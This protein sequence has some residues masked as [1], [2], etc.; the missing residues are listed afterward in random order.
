MTGNRK[1]T[2]WLLTVA[3]L[4]AVVFPT[5]AFAATGDVTSVEIEGSGT[6]LELTVG[7]TKQLRLNAKKEGISG[8]T[9]VTKL[10][11][12]EWSSDNDEIIKVSDGGVLT[13]LKSGTATITAEYNG[14]QS[15]IEVKAV[16]TYTKLTLNDPQDGKYKLGDSENLTVKAKA[17]VDGSGRRRTLLLMRIGPLRTPWC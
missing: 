17:V 2:G 16:D 7:K 1:L 5:G 14:S 4:L 12:V 6:V 10:S 9:D 8:T 15:T 3:L 11:G 13:A